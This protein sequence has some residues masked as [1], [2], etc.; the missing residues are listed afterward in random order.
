MKQSVDALY[1]VFSRITGVS[2][3]HIGTDKDIMLPSG[4]A[5][6]PSAAAHCLLEMKRTAVFLRGIHQAILQK[7]EN[8]TSGP[9][10][11]LY[12][13]TGPYGTLV[14]PLLYLFTPD[15]IQV[16]LLDINPVSLEALRKLI[17]EL[18]LNDY[19]GSVFCEDATT[20][21]LSRHYDIAISETML[22]C[23]KSEPQVAVMQNIIPQLQPEAIFIPEEI[24]I[25]AALTNPK[26]EQDRLLYYENEAPP[27]RRIAL[28]NVFAVNKQNLDTDRMQKT[29]EI[30]DEKDFPVLKLFTTVKVFGS[31]Q[32][33]E[34]DS[35]ITLPV[36]FYD[37]R[38]QPTLHIAF[39]YVQGEKPHIESRVV[40]K[41]ALYQTEIMNSL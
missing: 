30:P 40:C 6:S 39:W 28:G 4:K 12:A 8:N 38:K 23:L 41:P 27:F 36:N 5:I 11:I 16:D 33:S 17:D 29:I 19:I 3:A 18:Q 15:K 32:L 10:H 13:G 20:F 21:T 26:M 35:S 7:I 1:N 22:A 34:N 9:I 14:I 24:C 31:E 25:D 2:P 37:L